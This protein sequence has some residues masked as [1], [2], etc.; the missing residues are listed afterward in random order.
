MESSI[1]DILRGI[2]IFKPIESD[3]LAALAAL[4]THRRIKSGATVIAEGEL[5]DEMYI[6][7]TGE[8]QVSKQTLDNERYTVAVLKEEQHPFFGEMAMLDEERRSATI[9][10]NKP[11]E[12]LV[13][14]RADFEHFSNE[15]PET[16]LIMVRLLAKHVSSKLRD[17]NE[18]AVLLFEA[19]VNEVR[20]KEAG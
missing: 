16:G 19:L 10:A 11:S 5:G 20:S 1:L 13:L 14:K 4:M 2:P 6:L 9:T 17:A 12:M 3:K 18:D 15:H 8:V 7:L